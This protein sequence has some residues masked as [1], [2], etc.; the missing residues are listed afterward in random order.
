MVSFPLPRSEC[1]TYKFGLGFWVFR[2][3]SKNQRSSNWLETFLVDMLTMT[4][5]SYRGPILQGSSSTG[6]GGEEPLVTTA[7]SLASP[8]PVGSIVSR[9]R[10]RQ[11]H[12]TPSPKKLKTILGGKVHVLHAESLGLSE[13]DLD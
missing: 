2:L 8:K 10:E 13:S 12:Y 1:V 6:D 11:G 5:S 4:R 9:K 3:Y 7:S